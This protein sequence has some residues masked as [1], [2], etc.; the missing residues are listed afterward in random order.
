MRPFMPVQEVH[1]GA[2]GVL[3]AARAAEVK[4]VVFT[5]SIS[6]SRKS[7]FIIGCGCENI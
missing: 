7:H 3:E 4:R 5:S 1:Q 2:L 6:K